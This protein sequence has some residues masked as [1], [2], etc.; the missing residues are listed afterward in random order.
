MDTT[1]FPDGA[2]VWHVNA[3]RTM[4]SL[5]E[6]LVKAGRTYSIVPD[7]DSDLQGISIGPYRTCEDAMA[8][9]AA[10]LGGVCRFA[11]RRGPRLVR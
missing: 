5:G 6:I 10:H 1:V 9:I 11:E 4:R 8:A 7:D 3:T 2:G